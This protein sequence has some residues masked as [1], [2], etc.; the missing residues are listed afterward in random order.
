MIDEDS[1]DSHSTDLI[2]SGEEGLQQFYWLIT[3]F[4]FN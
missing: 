4:G 2:I 1:P 3:F